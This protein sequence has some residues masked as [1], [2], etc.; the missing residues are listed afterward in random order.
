MKKLIVLIG[1]GIAFL[2]VVALSLANMNVINLM[3]ADTSYGG[4]SGN[5]AFN[6]N[7]KTPGDA[8]LTQFSDESLESLQSGL[9]GNGGGGGSLNLLWLL[10]NAVNPD[11]ESYAYQLLN[12]YSNLENGKYND[13]PYHIS[14]EA[15]AG[16]HFNETNLA[17]FVTPTTKPYANATSSILGK[18][19]NG[20]KITLENA[21][22]EDIVGNVTNTGRGVWAD[23]AQGGGDGYPDG[24]FQIINGR[25]PDHHSDKNRSDRRYDLYNFVDAANVVDSSYNQIAKTYAESGATPDPRAIQMLTA[26]AHNRGDAGVGWS[27]FGLPYDSNNGSLSKY[28]KHN[29]IASMTAEELNIAAQYPKDL[30]KW[31]DATNIPLE[32]VAGNSGKSRGL[33]LLLNLA[34]GGFIDTPLQ[35]A[36]VKNIQSLGDDII[37]KVMPGQNKNTIIA[38][39]NNTYV[40][41]PWSVLGMSKSE[42][43]KVYGSSGYSIYE[44]GF[45]IPQGH[46]QNTSFY[47]DKSLKSSNYKAGEHVV[48]RAIE[49]IAMGYVLDSGILGTYVVLNIALEAGIKSLTNGSIVDPSNPSSIYQ[50]K[51]EEG[52]YNPAG[53]ATG[54]Y[55]KFLEG[56]GLAGKLSVTQQAQIKAIYEVSGGGYSQPK[57]GTKAPNGT[58]YMDC[59]A[60]ATIGLFMDP[61]RRQFEYTGSIM[62]G[63]WLR[64]T[65]QTA[66]VDGKTYSTK[67]VQLDKNGKPMAESNKFNFTQTMKDKDWLAKLQTGDIVNGRTGGSGHVWT[68]LGQNNTGKTVVLTQDVSRVSAKYSKYEPGQHYTI[69]ASGYAM[70]SG[71]N[72]MGLSPMLADSSGRAYHAMR[73]IYN[74]K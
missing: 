57:R 53:T 6:P 49:G 34:N 51:E 23:K 33:G 24:P 9:L 27:L 11:K 39:I 18:T 25:Q 8:P 65:G 55:G 41:T 14:P 7:A 68:Y 1:V 70:T 2:V 28:L 54:T 72:M 42:Y 43:D 61:H 56:L 58:W 12:V 29:T 15:I 44:Q 30:L 21:K 16:S 45:S 37:N 22:R 50:K 73:P 64:S 20:K 4:G 48:V 13:L 19:I 32:A 46:N 63:A 38:H 60:M 10:Q 35:S 36:S 47:I 26:L 67:V 71:G 59:S 69:Q 62:D 52:V 17:S 66:V 74:I 40:K 5:E 3:V 31:F